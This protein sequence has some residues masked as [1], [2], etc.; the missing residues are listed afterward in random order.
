MYTHYVYPYNVLCLYTFNTQYRLYLEL[1]YLF[2]YVI[3][4]K[5]DTHTVLI[6]VRILSL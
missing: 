6:D 1:T 5:A 3:T 4:F 2:I